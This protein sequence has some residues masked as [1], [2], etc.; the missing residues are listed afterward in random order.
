MNATARWI[1]TGV[2]VLGLAIDAYTHFDLAAQY[3]FNR[4]STVSQETLFRIEAVLAIVAAVAIIVRANVWTVLLAVAVAGGGLALLLIYRYV[5]VGEL[6]P[7]P[8]MY[9]PLWFTEKSWSAAGEAVA[10]LAGLALL[11]NVVRGR[12]RTAS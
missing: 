4:T 3:Q 2:V 5:N 7:I 11:V 8:N 1:L 6:G 12:R 9:E 10:T